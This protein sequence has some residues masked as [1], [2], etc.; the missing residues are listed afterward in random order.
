MK[1]ARIYLTALTGFG[2]MLILAAAIDAQPPGGP[3]PGAPPAQTQM[4]NRP[5]IAVFNMVAVM[6]DYKKAKYKVWE[7][8]EEK[9]KLTAGLTGKKAEYVDL[10]QKVQIQQDPNVKDQ[11]QKRMVVLA[12]ELEDANR[13]IQKRLDEQATVIIGSL[14]DEIKLVVDKT[15]EMNGYHIVFAYPDAAGPEEAKSP[16]MKELKLKPPA[17][18]PFFVSKHV[19]ITAIVVQTLNTWYPS[20][21][22]PPPTPQQPAAGNPTRRSAAALNLISDTAAGRYINRQRGPFEFI[23]CRVWVKR[24]ARVLNTPLAQARRQTP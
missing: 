4:A 17:A 13:E 21:D 24:N 7:L 3:A 19:D 22:P 23:D 16:Y 12:R 6:K 18:F 11:M 8:S 20:Q 2:I 9:K 5:T 1:R 10:Q 14:Y 15:A